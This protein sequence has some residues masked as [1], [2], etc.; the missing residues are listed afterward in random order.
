MAAPFPSFPDARLADL[1]DEI[2]QRRVSFFERASNT[3]PSTLVEGLPALAAAAALRS[4]GADEGTL[5]LAMEDSAVLVPVWNNGPDAERFVGQFRLPAAEGITGW[6]FSSGMA[7]CESEVCLN[8]KQ[9]RQLDRSLNVLTWAMLAVP[10]RLVG[11]RRGVMTAVRLIRL[12]TLP[13]LQRIPEARADFPPGFEPPD[14][15]SVEDLAAV[16]V[17]AQMI[18]RL[19]DH[20]LTAWAMD[21]DE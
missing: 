17:A 2:A 12:D 1:A 5:W 6:V 4:I 8:Q 10:L 11:E 16:E 19:V 18:G 3:C 14:S 13:D 21:W 7:S 20:R 15:F 9:N